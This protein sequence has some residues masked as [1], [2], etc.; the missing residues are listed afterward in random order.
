[1][2]LLVCSD[3]N[4][5]GIENLVFMGICESLVTERQSTHYH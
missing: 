2:L 5:P 3:V 1:M 4:W